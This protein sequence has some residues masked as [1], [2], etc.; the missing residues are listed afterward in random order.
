MTKFVNDCCT[1][2][3]CLSVNKVNTAMLYNPKES[4]GKWMLSGLN[5]P[6]MF[7]F[8]SSWIQCNQTYCGRQSNAVLTME[9]Q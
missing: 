6:T 3:D 1:V 7:E 2:V 9:G 8:L 5:V 4:K